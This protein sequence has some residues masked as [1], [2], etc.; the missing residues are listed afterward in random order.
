MVREQNRQAQLR[1]P[2]FESRLQNFSG[3]THS[4]KEPASRMN[5]WKADEVE[6]KY[7]P[8][9]PIELIRAAL[10]RLKKLFILDTK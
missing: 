1:K 8:P 3:G 2:S 10:I 5:F 4:N 6:F 7:L 9:K